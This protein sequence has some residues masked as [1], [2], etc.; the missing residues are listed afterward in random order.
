M[1]IYKYLI[2]IENLNKYKIT[3]SIKISSAVRGMKNKY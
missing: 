2:S 1:S 3:I